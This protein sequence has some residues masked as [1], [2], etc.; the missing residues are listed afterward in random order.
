MTTQYR[1]F[2]FNRTTHNS[3]FIIYHSFIIHHTIDMIDLPVYRFDLFLFSFLIIL[4]LIFLKNDLQFKFQNEIQNE[5]QNS[6]FKIQNS[7]IFIITIIFFIVIMTISIFI[8]ILTTI[9]CWYTIRMISTKSSYH[10]HF[11]IM[12]FT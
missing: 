2:N 11:I 6:Q 4:Y 9:T 10:F 3:H 1:N 5:I 7:F 12:T 8:S